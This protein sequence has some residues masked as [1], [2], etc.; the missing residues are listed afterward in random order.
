MILADTSA[1]IEFLR[2]TGSPVCDLVDQLLD[3]DLT[4]CE[5][6]QM[7]VLAGAKD[8]KH[9]QGLREMLARATL[10]PIYRTDYDDAAALYRRCRRE[11]ATVRKMLDCLVAAVAIRNGV[12]VLHEDRDFDALARHTELEV[13]TGS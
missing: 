12:P 7:E 9:L 3:G 5:A 4:T 6:V 8:E 1:W 2:D 10:L 13:Y 11:G